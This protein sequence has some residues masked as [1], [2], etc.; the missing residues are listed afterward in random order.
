VVV[1]VVEVK[2][3]EGDGNRQELLGTAWD[4]RG[5][6]F[7][8]VERRSCRA[9][10]DELTAVEVA[11]WVD[12]AVVMRVD[13]LVVVLVL[14]E[15]WEAATEDFRLFCLPC[16]LSALFFVGVDLRFPPSVFT[17]ASLDCCLS[18]SGTELLD[19]MLSF[20]WFSLLSLNTGRPASASTYRSPNKFVPGIE[21]LHTYVHNAYTKHTHQTLISSKI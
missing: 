12:A 10:G 4:W 3:D 11:M 5:F 18:T 19:D 6:L 7:G 20:S 9:K 16:A 15:G 14:G 8:G 2:V 21:T 17:V 1:V 13:G